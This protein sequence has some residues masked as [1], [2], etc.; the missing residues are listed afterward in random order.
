MDFIASLVS[1]VKEAEAS[2]SKLVCQELSIRLN[3]L[4]FRVAGLG[5]RAYRKSKAANPRVVL[6]GRQYGIIRAL[7]RNCVSELVL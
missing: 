5:F 3:G 2:S 4:G 7:K 6:G 1:A